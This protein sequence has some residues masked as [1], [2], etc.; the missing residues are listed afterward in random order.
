MISYLCVFLVESVQFKAFDARGKG[1]DVFLLALPLDLRTGGLAVMVQV[2]Q[3][4]LVHQ[5]REFRVQVL[6]KEADHSE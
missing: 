3:V 4:D 5:L 1:S 2:E 6:E